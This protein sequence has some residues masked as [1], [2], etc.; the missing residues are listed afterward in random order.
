MCIAP[1]A[2]HFPEWHLIWENANK[3][4]ENW[5]NN[6][7]SSI[8]SPL[9][10]EAALLINMKL[11]CCCF[12]LTQVIR[13]TVCLHA[14]TQ[15]EIESHILAKVSSHLPP[16]LNNKTSVSIID[17]CERRGTSVKSLAVGEEQVVNFSVRQTFFGFSLGGMNLLLLRERREGGGGG[18]WRCEAGLGMKYCFALGYLCGSIQRSSTESKK[19]QHPRGK[20]R[21]QLRYIQYQH[22]WGL[23]VNASF[24]MQQ[25]EYLQHQQNVEDRTCLI[26]LPCCPGPVL[27]ALAVSQTLWSWKSSP[28]R[29]DTHPCSLHP[30]RSRSF[31]P[32]SCWCC[33]SK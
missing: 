5:I 17:S 31:L 15:T 8:F 3:K 9:F 6:W 24:P 18:W 25:K 23:V 32:L 13:A 27:P 14:H 30:S 29:F 28:W 7:H 19:L 10:G 16:N 11:N 12:K 33:S 26:R 2:E 4:W 22:A 1:N 20:T 21:N